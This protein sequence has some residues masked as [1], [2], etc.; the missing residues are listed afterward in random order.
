MS[1]THTVSRSYRDS[2]GT[3]ITSTETVVSN[4]EGNYDD[5]I[6]D[7][8]TNME[9][10]LVLNRALLQSL[11]LFSSNAVSIKTNGTGSAGAITSTSLNTAGSGY[12]VGDTGTISGG[13]AGTYIITGIGASGAVVGYTVTAAGSAY[14]KT[15]AVVTATGGA[16]AGSGTGFK[17]N[18]LTIVETLSLLAGQNKVWTLATD[19]LAGLPFTCDVNKLYYTNVSGSTATIKV[20]SLSDVTP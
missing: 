4:T 13:T 11:S 9:V 10:D 18:I 7:S 15:N 2:S 1:F 20:R 12:A 19:A 17:I 3:P 16:Q 14:A 8:T 6:P 5:T